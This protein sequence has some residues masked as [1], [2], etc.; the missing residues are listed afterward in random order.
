MPKTALI[1]TLIPALDSDDDPSSNGFVFLGSGAADF[2]GIAALFT[3]VENFYNVTGTSGANPVSH[4][5][6]R[7]LDRGSS[8]CH[9]T[10]YD[11][12]GHLDGSP[13]GSPVAADTWT[14][15]GSGAVNSVPSGVAAAVSFRADYG[16]DVE[17]G[18][19]TRPRSRDRNRVY[20]GPLTVDALNEDSV[21][22]RVKLSNTFIGDC[23][24]ALFN[25]SEAVGI[26]GDDWVLQTWSRKNASTKLATEGFMD[27]RPDYQR[28][29]S[30]PGNKTFRA[31]S[32]V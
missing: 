29:R 6:G 1:K 16:T 12:T 24:A 8:H 3:H 11:I 14:L 22:H 7:Q 4:Y 30:D 18:V 17:F 25:L 31:L 15:G 9:I 19:G 21:T 10:A 27:D 32:A 26:G 20:I 23:L 5:M 13:H 2:S 28:R